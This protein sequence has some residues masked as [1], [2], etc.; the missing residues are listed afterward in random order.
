MLGLGQ[1]LW[2]S[3]KTVTN[4]WLL[5]LSCL[6]ILKNGVG[7]SAKFRETV[8]SLENNDFICYFYAC[9]CF[10]NFVHVLRLLSSITC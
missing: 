9:L 5:I 10:T 8:L 2:E 4:V 7:S 6:T 3:F 1:R